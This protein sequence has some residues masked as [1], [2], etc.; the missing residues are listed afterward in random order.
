MKKIVLLLVLVALCHGTI[1]F[2]Q[3]TPKYNESDY[4]VFNFSIE[5]I[6]AYRLGYIVVY[7]KTANQMAHA[8]LPNEWF[9]DVGGVGEIV[10]L[11]SGSEWPSITVFYKNGEFS[12]VRLRL[13]RSRGHETWGAIPL[14]INLDEYFQGVEEVRL[15]H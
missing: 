2:A 5:K 14:S 12:H 15:E 13:R 1:L 4:Y 9:T 11:G 6:Y 3:Q 7:R 8:Y 10:M